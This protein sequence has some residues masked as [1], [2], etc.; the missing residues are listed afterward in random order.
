[1]EVAR[2]PASAAPELRL[3]TAEEGEEEVAGWEVVGRM[4]GSKQQTKVAPAKA[5]G[6]NK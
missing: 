2:G 5:V 6:G 1:M 3:D 4:K